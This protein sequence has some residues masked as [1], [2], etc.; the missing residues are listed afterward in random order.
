MVRGIR[1][2]CI[3]LLLTL[4]YIFVEIPLTFIDWMWAPNKIIRPKKLWRQYT[5]EISLIISES[6]RND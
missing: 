6:I 1:A 5:R 3:I 2:I 4:G